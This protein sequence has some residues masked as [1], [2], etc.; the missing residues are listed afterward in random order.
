MAKT[1]NNGM[2][3]FDEANEVTS[4]FV[5]FNVPLEDKIMG[6]LIAVREVKST[7]P[8]KAGKMEKVYDL[9]ADYGSFHKL[10]K[11]K[12]LIEEPVIVN[13]GEVWS[14]SKESLDSSM[15]NVKLGQKVGFKFIEEKEAKQA[16]FNPAKIVKVF[17]PKNEDNTYKMDKEWLA[18]N[19]LDKPEVPWEN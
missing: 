7:L 17:T 8:T 16:G 3:D 15:R 4:N 14:V 10:D 6:T 11:K 9:K 1:K 12:K 18:E 13:E 5:S 2:D 19:G